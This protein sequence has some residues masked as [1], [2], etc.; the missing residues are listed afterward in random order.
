M[1]TAVVASA[2]VNLEYIL[3][4]IA[5]AVFISYLVVFFAIL[6]R[7]P[8]RLNLG[9][10]MAVRRRWAAHVVRDNQAIT[11]VQTLR[12]TQNAANVF[13]S[14]AVIVAFFAFQ[15][16]ANLSTSGQTLQAVKFYVLGA[17]FVAGFL[18]FGIS[19]RESEH[20]GYLSYASQDAGEWNDIEIP[21]VARTKESDAAIRREMTIAN[22][23]TRQKVAGEAA[24]HAVFY[25][26]MGLRMFYLAV[27]I[28]GWVASPIACLVITVVM[29]VVMYFLDRSVSSKMIRAV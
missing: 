24:A 15:Q 13:A 25:W 19:L 11:A 26:A 20:C 17:T 27:C 6:W 23:K 12:N 29:V 14:A 10:K 7:H 5:A 1:S 2:Q 21:L 8:L 3:P 16:A 18:M 28:G 9:L 4:P 22:P